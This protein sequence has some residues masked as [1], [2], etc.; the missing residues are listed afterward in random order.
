M[1]G[2]QHWHITQLLS[3]VYESTDDYDQIKFVRDANQHHWLHDCKTLA[4]TLEKGSEL[5]H[6]LGG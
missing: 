6:K 5:P 1:S 4:M 3:D 2:C